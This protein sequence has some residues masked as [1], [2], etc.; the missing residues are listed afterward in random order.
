MEEGS[1][2]EEKCSSTPRQVLVA[3]DATKNNK[4]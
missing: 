1:N 3:I 2:Q 4:S